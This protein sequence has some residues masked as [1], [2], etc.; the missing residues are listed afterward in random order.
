MT[1]APYRCASCVDQPNRCETC[2]A[3]RAD[4]LAA[5]RAA[6][7]AAG[8]CTECTAPIV[9][10]VTLG[11]THVQCELHRKAG[12]RRAA[13]RR[14]KFAAGFVLVLGFLPHVSGC[15]ADVAPS[16][17]PPVLAT[18][19][20]AAGA[21]APAVEPEPVTVDAGTPT[22]PEPTPAGSAAPT[23]VTPSSPPVVGSPAGAPAPAPTPEPSPAGAPA[24]APAPV[25]PPPP[26]LTQCQ[27][28]VGGVVGCDDPNLINYSI[29]SLRWAVDPSRGL[30]QGNM[31]GCTGPHDTATAS[32]CVPGARCAFLDTSGGDL[33]HEG[34]C[35]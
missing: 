11:V 33:Y 14:A 34:T 17:A 28:D 13:A 16:E 8:T 26:H 5:R 21:P 31:T 20:S 29:Y 22:T 24:P 6:R 35:I 9:P 32:Q 2:R 27:L 4:A 23:P 15:A 10:D 1:F 25:T 7:R 19:G 18:Y 3:K 30:V 12:T